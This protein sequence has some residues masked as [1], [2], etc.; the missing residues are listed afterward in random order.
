MTANASVDGKARFSFS[1]ESDVT[2]F[3]ETLERFERGEIDSEEWRL[4]RLLH[5]NYGQRQGQG[6]TMLRAKLPQGI[7][8]ADQLE[9]L[10]EVADRYARGF[11][12]VTTRQNVQ[13]HFLPEERVVAAMAD[14]AK[15]GI[16]T[17]EACGNSV[18]N[19]TTSADAGVAHDEVFD[20]VPYA[21]TF[22]RHFLRHPL[23]SSLPRKFKV[24]F[25]GGGEDHAFALVNDIGYFARLDAEGRRGFRVTVA[26]GTA[27]YCQSGHELFAFVPAGDLLR[28]AEA[29]L[30]VFHDHG[31]RKNRK[32]N[33]MKFLVKAL[34]FEAFSAKVHDELARAREAKGAEL[35]FEP[36]SPP[37]RAEP[38][39]H[40]AVLVTLAELDALVAVDSPRG[41]GIV[42]VALPVYADSRA[43]R[44]RFFAS[45][46]RPQ[47]Q[48]GYFR[49]TVTLPL[50]DVSSGRARAL[51]LL[52]RA[53][54]DG[55]LR[56]THA[57]NIV[58]H[59]IAER[60][61]DALYTGLS[62]VGLVAADPDTIA[63]PSS[64]PGAETCKLAVT[65]SR[66]LS[67]ALRAH[68]ARTDLVAR[69]KG[70]VVKTSGC[71]NGCGLHHVA[72]L[73]FQGGLRK[74][75]GR[76]A[77]H[78]FLYVGGDP[79]GEKAAFGRFV[80]KIPARRVPAT[81]ERLVDYYEAERAEG[82]AILE[83]LKRQDTK[84][85]AKRLSDLS[86]LD[87]SN[88]TPEDFVD[89]AETDPFS[90]VDEDEA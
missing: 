30:Q 6:P 50:G 65:Q 9:V 32:K 89:F 42:P 28:V 71:P 55:T 5:G 31:D 29:V 43:E 88:A 18:R 12:H 27:T 16:T 53:Y 19:V 10:A 8:S 79:R 87:A 20:V 35:P 62:R 38:A 56:T 72:G 61:L 66:G 52:S 60:D 47:K 3:V 22:T 26:G 70:L 45:N 7:L 15:A 84:V 58:F 83:W 90:A 17:R 13:F 39:P 77:P 41:P 23:S 73:G 24:A 68:A 82:E 1:S 76:A 86:T 33:R 48:S 54:S 21:E 14:L 40:T 46:V 69:T 51:A 85:L 2:R 34:G 67:E 63:D 80:T 57:Q 49:V 44:L 81:V 37:S 25:S 4:F 36:E 74:V 59:W 75:D 64:C 78:Y 11:L